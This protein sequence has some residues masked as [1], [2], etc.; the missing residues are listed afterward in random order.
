MTGV[1]GPGLFAIRPLAGDVPARRACQKRAPSGTSVS[2]VRHRP[3]A[4]TSV[5]E[6]QWS[7]AAVRV[8]HAATGSPE[9]SF[10]ATSLHREEAT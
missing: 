9:L 1:A 4:R 10:T 8:M 7:A 6:V 2:M 3:S 5:H